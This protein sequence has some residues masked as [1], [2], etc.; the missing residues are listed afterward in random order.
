VKRRILFV[1]RDRAMREHL[2]LSFRH[3]GFCV[4]TAP[5]GVAGLFQLGLCQP[6]LIV[7]DAS[8][9]EVLQRIRRLSDIP[10]IVLVEDTPEAKIQSLDQ[11][12]D[13]FVV[14]PP[15]V[16]ELDARARVLLRRGSSMQSDEVALQAPTQDL[17][18]SRALQRV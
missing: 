4:V 10:V 11:G 3:R 5:D 16:G 6:H 7:L 17:S 18:D 15:S 1:V 9:W 13:F 14:K 12:A 8:G 2:A